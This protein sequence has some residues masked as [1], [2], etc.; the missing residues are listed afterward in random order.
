MENSF[1][2]EMLLEIEAN[3]EK[4]QLKHADFL[5]KEIAGLNS[6]ISKILKQAEEEKALIEEWSISRSSKLNDRVEWLTR[7]LQAF[8]DQE[9]PET[10]SLDLAHGQLLRRKQIE[11]I[12]VEDLELFMQ[13]NNLSDLITTSPEV[14]KPDLKKIKA[15]YQMSKKIPLGTS[16][17]ESTD[18]FSIKIKNGETNGTET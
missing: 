17:V 11:K 1:I 15:F 10:R 6:E 2:D 9:Y 5:L 8:M 18:K 14:I 13:N 3:E 16:L 7:K 4:M 12:V